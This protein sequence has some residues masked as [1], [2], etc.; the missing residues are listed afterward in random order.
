MAVTAA[1]KRASEAL[2]LAVAVST[3]GL[4]TSSHIYEYRSSM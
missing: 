3:T 4:I 1:L 2:T